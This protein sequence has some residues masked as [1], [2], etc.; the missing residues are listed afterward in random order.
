MNILVL[1]ASGLAGSAM[2]EAFQSEGHE[3]SGTCRTP[4]H[5]ALLPFDLDQPQAIVPLLERVRPDVV[6]SSLRGEFSRQLEAHRL[7]AEFLSRHHGTLVYLSTANVFDGDLSRPHYE[8]DP[9]Q[10]HSAYGQFKAACETL[11]QARLGESLV[12]LRPPEIWGLDCPRLH[13]LIRRLRAGSPVQTYENLSVNYAADTQIARWTAFILKQGLRGVFHVGTQDISDYT[14][15]LKRLAEGLNLPPPVFALERNGIPRYQAVL[16]GRGEI[17][18][19]LQ[20]SV[21][22]V[23]CGLTN[24]PAL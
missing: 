22:D 11:L 9:P 13:D 1:G 3:V 24:A 16:P 14:L 23:L 17:P 7:L 5:T 10:P 20:L 21:D 2:M 12:I 15:F 19:R 18:A 8:G 6:V 4:T